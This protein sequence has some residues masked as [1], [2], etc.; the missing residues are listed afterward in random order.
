MQTLNHFTI[1]IRR[2]SRLPKDKVAHV[3]VAPY[4]L[5][6][7]SWPRE[8]C[9]IRSASA[10][11]NASVH[12][13]L[14]WLVMVP[15]RRSIAVRATLNSSA[16]RVSVSDILPL[17]CPPVANKLFNSKSISSLKFICLTK[18]FIYSPDGRAF[19]G[20]KAAVGTGCLRCGFPVYAAEQ[21]IS[22]DRIWHKR[23]FSCVECRKSLDSTNLN[24]GPD[25][26]IYC[27][28]CY[29]RNF[30]PKGVGFGIGA[31]TLTMV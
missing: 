13:T 1:R 14:P 27:R 21:M 11:L 22:K 7:S 31:G 9:G 8:L 19:T 3:V 26:E 15:I 12:W 24:D 6:N 2:Q 5:P 29:G 28:G 25:G 4:L 18:I 10:V 20:P 23:C 17:W 30:G 16:P